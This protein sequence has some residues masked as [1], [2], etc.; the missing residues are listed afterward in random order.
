MLDKSSF[1]RF[2]I[3]INEINKKYMYLCKNSMKTLP[4]HWMSNLHVHIFKFLTT[5]TS[6]F[7]L[8]ELEGKGHVYYIE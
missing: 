3:A 4:Y 6:L 5:S 1:E 8:V 7:I 2:K